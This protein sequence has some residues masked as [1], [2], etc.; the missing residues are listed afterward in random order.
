[1]SKSSIEDCTQQQI[2]NRPL[3]HIQY[4]AECKRLKQEKE[5]ISLARLYSKRRIDAFRLSSF[6]ST[7]LARSIM[8][9]AEVALLDRKIRK[10]LE[11]AIKYNPCEAAYEMFFYESKKVLGGLKNPKKVLRYAKEAR[12]RYPTNPLFLA[13]QS[14]AHYQLFGADCG[15][16][17]DA[18][19]MRPNDAAFLSMFSEHLCDQIVTDTS[20]LE[21]ILFEHTENWDNPEI[22][23]LASNALA[24]NINPEGIK[25]YPNAG[26]LY[27]LLRAKAKKYRN[28]LKLQ[29]EMVMTGAFEAMS[30]E[31][32]HIRKQKLQTAVEEL[33]NLQ[34]KGFDVASAKY[35]HFT[36]KLFHDYEPEPTLPF[37]NIIHLP[38]RPRYLN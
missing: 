13:Y 3:T 16:M 34:R 35:K 6:K 2:R 14:R 25:E 17:N 12:D 32:L 18:V 5:Y 38:K 4:K 36:N 28:D 7:G 26:L 10:T 11:K 9:S 15:E 27:G 23:T 30:D 33:K 37:G 8:Y 1:M 29:Y 22:L 19:D 21:K 20:P 31:D 24:K